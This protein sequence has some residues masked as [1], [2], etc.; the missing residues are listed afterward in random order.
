MKHHTP[1]DYEDP[2][3]DDEDEDEYVPLGD[4]LRQQVAED[5]NWSDDE[6]PDSD[7]RDS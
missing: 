4:E 5:E 7:D 1:Q 2:Y 3:A 6:Y